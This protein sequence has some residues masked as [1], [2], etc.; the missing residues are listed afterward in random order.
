MEGGKTKGPINAPISIQE[1]SD[2]QCP[3]C[4]KATQAVGEIIKKY[5]GK[6]RISFFH[7]PLK[8]HSW[9]ALAHQCAE[10]ATQQGKFWPF[11][12][13]LY[14]NQ[15]VWSALPNPKDTF[16]KYAQDLGLDMKLFSKCVD[17]NLGQG[18]I[19]EDVKRGQDL[20]INSTPTF[21]VNGKRI[22]G[23]KTFA[24][25]FEKLILEEMRK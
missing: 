10:C 3:A 22:I 1:F 18:K 23:G 17:E 14:L 21:F 5:P 7:F 8:M 20:Q 9:A 24:E 12:D 13:Q 19:L 4:Q 2:F 15:S 11:H 16:R 25:D 6:M